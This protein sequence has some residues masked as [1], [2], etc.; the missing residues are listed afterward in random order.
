MNRISAKVTAIESVESVSIVAFEAA[1]QPMRMMSL[2]LDG[3]LAAG[4]DV[5]LGVKASSIALAKAFEGELSISN[6]LKMT[7]ESMTEGRL[8]CSVKLRF[9]GALLESIITRESAERLHLQ[10]GDTVTALIK[11]SDVSILETVR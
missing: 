1:G 7:V 8:L 10:V 11:A 5:I 4:R 3:T 2:E 9:G 6:R